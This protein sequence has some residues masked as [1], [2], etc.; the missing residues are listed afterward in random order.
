MKSIVYLPLDERPC[1]Y[2]FPQYL[3][4]LTDL[5]LRV[6]PRA[7]LGS[8]KRPSDPDRVR[9]WLLEQVRTADYA[10]L[11]I[12]QLVYGGIVPSRL[13]RLTE[14][15]C[16]ERLALARELK[17]INPS[18]KLLAFNL[19]MRAPAYSSSEEEPDYYALYGAELCERGKLLD[20]RQIGLTAEEQSRLDELLRR[21]PPAVVAEFDE[22]RRTNAVVN[23]AAIDLVREGV[24]DHLTIPLDD[25][26][27]YGFTAMEQRRLKL[28]VVTSKLSH[29]V[30]IY[31]GAD[32]IGCTLLARA[33]TEAKQFRPGVFVRYSA[34]KGPFVIP[35]Y[36]DRSLQESIKSHL[37]EAGAL[38]ADHAGDADAVLMVHAPAVDGTAAAEVDAPYEERHRSYSSEANLSSFA[39][40]VAHYADRGKVVTLADVA[41]SNGADYAL[42]D[43]LAA[44]R[45]IQRLDS[46]AGWNTSGNSLGTVIAHTVIE[47]YY[48]GEGQC[49]DNAERRRRSRWNF[50]YRLL[51]DWAYQANV[52]TQV[53][54]VELPRLG[55]DYFNLSHVK[56]KVEGIIEE[57]MNAFIR[58]SIRP[59]FGKRYTVSKVD[60]SW[61]RMFELSFALIE[62][63]EEAE[64]SALGAVQ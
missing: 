16:M 42:M 12:D 52:R 64:L 19:I 27:E 2:D 14:A 17:E 57:G 4:D 32:E 62:E 46:Y 21:I 1:N 60:L 51:D 39:D 22:R 56:A 45:L 11:S 35:K 44:R 47:A 10:I 48:R 36:E 53:C 55:A 9:D 41:L 24:I 8:K 18:V 37:H 33:F 28:K 20:R 31:P 3:A 58:E 34:S 30:S 26:A 29:A 38:F 40:A 15:A 63:E 13:H 54:L 61:E 6:P 25:N 49:E 5:E 43:L 59:L 7:M 23:E 50:M